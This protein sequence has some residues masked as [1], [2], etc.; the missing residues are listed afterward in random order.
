MKKLIA[1]LIS[2]TLLCGAALPALAENAAVTPN[3]EPGIQKDETVYILAAADGTAKR[4]IVSDYLS[5]PASAAELADVSSLSNI[6]NVKGDQTFENGVWQA[7]GEDI[8]YQGEGKTPLPVELNISYSLN[9]EPIAPDE[10]AGRDGHVVIRFDFSVNQTGETGLS[11]PYAFLTGA[12][13]ENDVF[14]NVQATNA[15]V[16]NDGDRTVVLGLA[17]PGLKDSLSLDFESMDIADIPEL[18][19]YVQIEADATDFA[20]PVTLTLATGEV[21][22]S[23]DADKLVSPQSLKDAV[24]RL[25]DG[26]AQLLDGGTQLVDGLASLDT[27]VEQLADG[28]NALADGLATLV[29]NN[30]DLVSGSTQVFNTLLATANSQLAAADA[31]VPEL[32]I[33]NYDETL[34]ALLEAMSED[35]IAR[36][37][38][39]QVEQAV[40]SRQDQVRAAVEQ[41][42]Q[43]EVQQQV[44]AAAEENVRAQVLAAAGMSVESYQAAL[45]AGQLSEDQVGQ[46]DAAVQQQ[47]AADEVQAM[48]DQQLAARLA[49]DEVQSV[50]DENTEAQ[51]QALIDQNMASDDVQ[52]Q[53]EQSLARYAES[54]ATLAALREQLNAYNVFHSGIVAYTRGASSAADGANQLRAGLPALEDGVAQLLDGARAMLDGLELFSDEAVDKLDRLAGE[55]LEQLL[56]RVREL[57][58]AAQVSRNY[59]GVA[60]GVDASARYIWRTDAIGD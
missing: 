49:S 28:V 26:M 16:V 41:A 12:L 36:Q 46:I 8:Y 58:C 3:D 30:D 22:A 33:D 43:A 50:I 13:L 19:E 15:R 5:N 20:L 23:L 2:L 48:I 10:L 52:A 21:F 25:S 44:Q 39:A 18:P 56:E 17:L 24:S 53:I 7:E 1:V 42:V 37:A 51:L 32:T 45:A 60:E 55:D 59:S 29:S 34:A 35:G 31:G 38:R 11:V 40:R 57:I 54:R 47:L 9:G 14:K 4:I 27:G 6:E